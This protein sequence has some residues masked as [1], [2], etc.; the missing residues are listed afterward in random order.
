MRIESCTN[1]EV[2]DAIVSHPAIY[3]HISDDGSPKEFHSEPLIGK[4]LFLAP[5]HENKPCGIFIVHQ[6]TFGMFEVHTCILPQYW[7][8]VAGQAAKS[9]IGWVFDN[10]RCRTLITFVPKPNRKALRFAK[11]AGL[12]VEGYVRES[13]VKNGVAHDQYLLAVHKED[14]CQ[15]PP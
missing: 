4:A 9:L 11:R 8:E 7:G 15:Q 6:H 14:T 10:T 1:P 2:I 5:I 13:Y 3:P 12:K